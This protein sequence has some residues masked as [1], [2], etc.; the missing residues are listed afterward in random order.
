MNECPH[1]IPYLTGYNCE[2]CS[3]TPEQMSPNPDRLRTQID[4]AR[5]W[6]S[7]RPDLN[8]RSLPITL[9]AVQAVTGEG[10]QS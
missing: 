7:E 2:W 10:D 5:A 1:V 8:P 4:E 6:G 9:E 3:A